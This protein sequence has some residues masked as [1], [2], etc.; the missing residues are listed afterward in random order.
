MKAVVAGGGIAGLTIAALLSRTGEH[1]VTVLERAGRYGEAGYGIGLYPLGAAVF[2][3][4]GMGE[5][6][7]RRG[8]P[9][10][11][12]A[13]H[14]P[15]GALLQSVSLDELLHDFGPM[16]GISRTDL[17]EVLASQVSADC[18][19]FGVHAA[20]VERTGN[21]VVVRASDGA[22]Y[23]GDVAI[24]ADGM[25]SALRASI[26]G[27]VEPYDTQFD[28]WMWW[29]PEGTGPAA[30]ASEH[31]GPSAFVGLYPMAGRVNVA[32]GVPRPLSPDP[33]SDPDAIHDALHAVVAEHAPGAAAIAG[34]WDTT[35]GTRPFLWPL[36]DYRAPDI[37]ALDNRVALVGDSG[38][39]FLPTA[40]VGASNA[41]RSA[42]ALAYEI[43]LAD[44]DNVAVAVAR[45]RTRVKKLVEGNQ[46]DSRQLAKVMMV[47][48]K[49]SSA[50]INTLMK[51]MPVTAMTRS[52]VASMAAPF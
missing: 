32:V 22:S 16:L 44:A 42:A 23:E 40:G 9:L 20:S 26:F 45:W 34:L 31:W 17:I 18:I 39:G 37:V 52:I 3:A 6:L 8:R 50:L 12:Y 27:D 1:E 14:G 25:H 21:G 43:S 10:T 46:H 48:H 7:R 19:R 36:L 28:A 24:A 29:A 35:Q 47:R 11:T 13:V 5:E 4:L 38:I 41:L 30:T 51:H 2:N 33:E 15:D 49:T